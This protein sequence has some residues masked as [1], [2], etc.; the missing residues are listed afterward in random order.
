MACLSLAFWYDVAIYCVVII[1]VVALLRLLISA[2][3]GASGPFWP[4]TFG[5]SPSGSGLLGFIA[6]A[7]NI[8]I[9]AVI[10]IFVIWLIFMLLS[11]LLGGAGW[12]RFPRP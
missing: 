6:A 5:V 1:A 3:G 7:L 2:L 4:P 12:P 8:I 11:C 10:V 9:W